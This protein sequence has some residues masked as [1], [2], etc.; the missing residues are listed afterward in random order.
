MN[1]YSKKRHV[2]LFLQ[3]YADKKCLERLKQDA[4]LCFYLSKP[5]SA[6]M[7]SHIFRF[8]LA[9]E[10]KLVTSIAAINMKFANVASAGFCM[11]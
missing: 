3:R 10:V 8:A 6:V 7:F 4:K 9:K 11:M 2:P 1:T 5:G